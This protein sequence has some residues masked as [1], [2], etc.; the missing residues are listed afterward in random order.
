MYRYTLGE[1]VHR[2]HSHAGRTARENPD[3]EPVNEEFANTQ[4]RI[5]QGRLGFAAG[6]FSPEPKANAGALDLSIDDIWSV[7][8][9]SFF[10]VDAR[11]RE[12][13]VTPRYN[14]TW[15]SSRLNLVTPR[16]QFSR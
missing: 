14:Q 1:A 4:E 11:C 2:P 7:A 6:S 8:M 10:V 9:Q 3:R 16:G 15:K 12:N 5:A 13:L